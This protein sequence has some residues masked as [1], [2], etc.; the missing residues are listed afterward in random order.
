MYLLFDANSLD[1]KRFGEDLQNREKAVMNLLILPV[2]VN[3]FVR[4][5][6]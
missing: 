1:A 3:L 6:N 5:E 4:I 2:F